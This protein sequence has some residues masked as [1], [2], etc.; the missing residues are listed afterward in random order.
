MKKITLVFFVMLLSIFVKA[1]EYPLV[2]I[3]DINIVA[4]SLWPSFPPSPLVGDT[5]RVRGVLMVHPIVSPSGDRSP[6]IWSG[7]RWAAYIQDPVNPVNGGLALIQNDT[8]GA[9][10]GTLFDLADTATVYEFTCVV[11]MYFQSVQCS[12][13]TTPQ[14]VA[15]SP[16]SALTKRPD[17]VPLTIDSFYTATGTYNFAMRKYQGVYVELRADANHPLITSDRVTGTGSASGNFK[18]NDL[19]GHFFWNYAQSRYYKSNAN[20]LRPT[21]QPPTDGSHLSY[22]R[23]VLTMRADA[24]YL[25]PLYPED[26]GTVTIAPPT[27]SG[28]RR[29]AAT[30]AFNQNVTV[31]ATARGTS[32]N[33]ASVKIFYRVNGGN[34]DSIAMTAIDSIS[35]TGVIPGRPD[36]SFVDYYIKAVDANNLSVTNPA[37]TVTS[38]YSYFTLNTPLQIQ[39]VRYSPFGSGFS[40]YNGYNVTLTGVVISDT[41]DIPGNHGSNPPRVYMQN[42]S[43]SWSGIVLGTVGANGTQVLS[44]KRGDNVTVNGTIALGS[45]GTRIDTL[46]SI[47]VNSQN[48]PMPI[49]TV[50]PTASVGTNSLG[51]L[52]TEPYNGTLVTYQNVVVD[53]ANAD[54]TSNFGECYVNNGGTHTRVI[55]SDGNTTYH[56]GLGLPTFTLVKKKDF[57]ESITGVL[58]YTHSQFKLCPRKNNDVVG[59]QPLAIEQISSALPVKFDLMQNYPNPF[60]PAT[61]ITYSI[62][63][64]ANV[65]LKVFNMLGEEISTLVNE[66]QNPGTYSVS[67]D[68]A[69]LTT[70]VYMYS[71]ST[72]GQVQVKKM[73]LI[74]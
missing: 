4:D 72:G 68:G 34:L 58:G 53:S 14:P 21:Y 42:G 6:I 25:V 50:L 22:I 35:Y 54:G 65:T 20:T 57:F 13:I 37:N 56:N 8:V 15:I 46:T 47:V 10:Q 52:T 48:N 73:L 36:S 60:N 44:L 11:A 16:V 59:Y 39:H 17:P 61:R 27:V 49:P 26:M 2:T 67:F 45:F 19:N 33:V 9:A 69:S 70:G 62:V 51:N 31:T 41:S 18:I 3:Q 38:R 43:G 66:S 24:Y 28:V 64:S 32:A 12:L 71:L 23:G 55:W 29:N 5:V 30:V 63:S 74:K 40:G 1:Q 7:A